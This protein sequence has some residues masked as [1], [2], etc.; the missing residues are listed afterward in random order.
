MLSEDELEKL[1]V[2]ARERIDVDEIWRDTT[3]RV[4]TIRQ[5][6]WI[7]STPKGLEAQL[8]DG[9][10]ALLAGQEIGRFT[11]YLEVRRLGFQRT[12][13][14][15]VVNLARVRAVSG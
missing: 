13:N 15:V 9:S 2:A 4:F 3:G 6:C 12:H 5:V 11:K 14:S 1:A 7:K 8:V 10:T